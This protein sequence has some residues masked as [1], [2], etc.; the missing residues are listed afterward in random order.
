MLL[1]LII[2]IMMYS[3]MVAKLQTY[4]EYQVTVQAAALGE[5][6]FQRL[7]GQL[8][9]LSRVAEYYRDDGVTEDVMAS[10]MGRLLTDANWKSCGIL[11]LGGEP[12][13]GAGLRTSEHPAVQRAFRGFSAIRYR[14]GEGLIF[15]TPVY[16]GENIKY[17]LYA[18]CDEKSL[19]SDFG[20][21]CYGGQAQLLLADGNQ[22]KILSIDGGWEDTAAYFSKGCVQTAIDKLKEKLNTGTSAAVLCDCTDTKEF[23]F[24]STIGRGNLYVIGKV[25]YTV[26]ADGVSFLSIMTLLVFGLLLAL[27]CIGTFNVF[28]VSAK[29][30]ESDELRAAKQAA[31]EANQSKSKFIANMTHE[32]RTPI[33]V[34]MGMDEMI[35]RETMEDSIRERAM[36]IKS[37]S[38]ILLGLI[39]DVLDYSKIEAGN[40]N[41]I[42]V[43]YDLVAMIRDLVLLSENRAR[44]K[45]LSFE[46]D[47]QQDLPSG[48]Y[49][50]DIH[51]RQ[52]LVNLLTNAVKYTEEGTVLL[53]ITGKKQ[54][55]DTILLH[56]AVKDT[57]IGIKD[58]DLRKLFIPFSR[59]EERRNRNVE[60]S[61]LGLSIIINL[62]RMMGSDLNVESVY[63]EGTVFW[64]ELEQKIINEEPVG[65]IRERLDDMV[66]E[67]KYQVSF[68]AP[69]ARILM[70]DD[71][72]L[73]RRLFVSLLKNTQIKIST[74]SSG[75]KALDL[76][77]H[78]YFDII[79]MDYLMPEM[80]GAETL[81][82]MRELKNNR[83]RNTPVIALTA[84]AY[85]GSREAYLEMGFADFLAKPI[86]T[87]KLE[88]LIWERLPKEYIES[89]SRKEVSE[90][91]AEVNMVQAQGEVELPEIEGI[92]WQH[93]QL[94]V[95]DKGILLSSLK[96][97]Y[98]NIDST[99]Q[100][101]SALAE[102]INTEE[103][104]S[105]Y[106]ICVH[107]LKSSAA[108]LGILMISELSRLLEYAARDG[109]REKISAVT[110]ILLEELQRIKERLRPVMENGETE[111]KEKPAAD[112]AKLGEC[113]EML[114][115]SM[116]QMDIGG[117]DM[118][119][120]QIRSYSYD[121]EL[122]E[123]VDKVGRKVKALDY[124]G[125]SEEIESC[126]EDLAL[127][128]R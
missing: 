17:V 18:L 22:Q 128:G 113:F 48:L 24:V 37:A 63:G 40:L 5:L 11:R 15:T 97:F 92:Q 10:S 87:E 78:E 39:N 117:A 32:L 91:R 70:V 90:D 67:Y 8:D 83:C 98:D 105:D 4:M 75:R 54:N 93:A 57:G 109:E 103:G 121:K 122:Q 13:Y 118:C 124:K 47:I 79:F 21:S 76:V 44:Q 89:V 50:D 45:S 27:L 52:I 55:D 80:D 125:A 126:R 42:P 20:Q 104:I 14:E 16:N 112:A 127:S 29:A 100:E 36:D 51:I 120:D 30:R 114:L 85:S 106:R 34:I 88:A 28:S 81:R 56:C 84:N 12:L 72:S 41:I 116:D 110:P 94:F 53:K 74:V 68:I 111:I 59:I 25:P 115:F 95:K 49:G 33:N 65:D 60:G 107:A 1:P 46:M 96:D 31:E 23:L 69:D 101:I 43:E 6:A 2:S 61:G 66:R 9:E 26:V 108:L 119:M 77:Q 38:Q 58:E 86:V 35:L 73:N 71:N 102:G 82:R 19:F 99:Y 62:L 123:I 7:S 3:R 64:F